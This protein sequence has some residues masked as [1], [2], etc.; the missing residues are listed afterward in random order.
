MAD[1]TSCSFTCSLDTDKK[2]YGS[3]EEVTLT[4]NLTNTH[5]SDTYVLKWHTPLEGM[6]NN[7]LLV[8]IDGKD[9]PYRG[10]MA[11]RGNPGAEEYILLKA[12]EGVSGSVLLKKGY[13]TDASGHY[14]V[15]MRYGR[16]LDVVPREEGVAFK[17]HT[18]NEFKR[19]DIKCGSVEFD[20]I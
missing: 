18:L 10:I 3:G 6:L 15:E 4:F 14:H 17:P 19:V 5:D 12:G 1:V 13:N 11:K 8:T 9:V 7:Y 2:S 16:L 20:R